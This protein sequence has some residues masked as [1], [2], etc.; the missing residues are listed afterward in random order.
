MKLVTALLALVLGSVSIVGIKQH[1]EDQARIKFWRQMYLRADYDSK[2]V[3]CVKVDSTS[4][5]CEVAR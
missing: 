5:V 4:A 3:N 1:R 2:F